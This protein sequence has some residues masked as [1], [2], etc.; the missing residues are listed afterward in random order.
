MSINCRINDIID[1]FAPDKKRFLIKAEHLTRYEFVKDYIQKHF[2]DKHFVIYDVGCGTGYG[3]NILKKTG[4]EII[5]FDKEAFY[6][7]A[8][9]I[10][11][12]V[13]SINELVNKNRISRPNVVVCFETLEHLKNPLAFLEQIHHLLPKNG[14]FICSIPQKRYDSKHSQFHLQSFTHKQAETL[15]I[16]N[17]F[18]IVA[19]Y[20]QPI[21]N[22]IVRYTQWF[23]LWLNKLAYLDNRIFLTLARVLAYPR[24]F[25]K[26][27]SYSIIYILNKVI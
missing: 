17:N 20:G 7:G 18:K 19:E 8:I 22:L 6:Q 27:K 25:L 3:I 15:L 14:Q 9:K 5:G 1:P 21:A 4:H 13:Q 16:K 10:D 11:L 24:T 23:S 26:N 12:D 2:L